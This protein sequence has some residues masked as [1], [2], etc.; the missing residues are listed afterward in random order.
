MKAVLLDIEGTTTPVEFVYQVLFPYARQRLA[1]FLREKQQEPE[2]HADLEALRKEH[3]FDRA[4]G[5]K[6]PDWRSEDTLLEA[7]VTY[8]QWLMDRD[9]KSTALKSLQGKIWEHGYTAGELRSEVYPDV[10]RAFSRWGSQKRDICIFSSGSTLAQKLLFAHTT[11]GDLT[12]FIRE[13][14]DTTTGKKAEAES[15]RRIAGVLGLSPP[16]ILFISDTVAELDA[17]HIAGMKTRLCVRP[18]RER[19][20]ASGHPIIEAF[21]ELTL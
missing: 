14:F 9:R 18:G 6:P 3:A 5:S 2:V 1:D 19:P 12:H 20:H 15:Y 7:V 10:P 21:D 17:A 8:V 11:A 13:Y 4:Q 16:E